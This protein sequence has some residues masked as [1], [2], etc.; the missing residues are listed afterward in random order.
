MKTLT[1]IL[2]VWILTQ[3]VYSQLYQ[4]PDTGSVPS[5]ASVT[6]NSFLAKDDFYNPFPTK[7]LRNKISVMPLSDETNI[8]PATGAAGSNI[9][10]DVSLSSSETVMDTYEPLYFRSFKGITMGNSIPP[11]P[12][13]AAGPDHFIAT[14]NTSFRISD[15]KGNTL[16]TIEA[17][18]WFNNVFTNAGAFDPKV[19][20]D[21]FAKRWIMVWLQQNDA[22]QTGTFLVSVSDDSNPIGTWYNW[23][24]PSSKNGSTPVSQ[25]GDYQGVGFD[26]NA[27]YLTTNQFSFAGSYQG[28]KI[29][30]IPKA[31]LYANTGGRCQWTDLWNVKD[32]VNNTQCFGIRPVIVYDQ[33]NYVYFL[34]QS[35]YTTGTYV[36]LFRLSNPLGT[37]SMTAVNIPVTE[38]YAPPNSSQLGTTTTIDAGSTSAFRFEPIV[39][40]RYMWAVHPVYNFGWSGVGYI[41]LDLNLNIPSEDYVYGENEYYFSYPGIAVDKDSN[42][43]IT[44]SRS[45]N[46]EYIGAYFTGKN[47]DASEFIG[48]KT[49]QAGKG[50]YVVTFGGSRNRWGD[51]MGVWLD[52][53]DESSF[54]LSTEY[55]ES[56]SNTWGVWNVHV[57]LNPYPG[58]RYYS[59]TDT[60][61]FSPT[62]KDFISDTM[63]FYFTNI[64][65]NPL[66]IDSLSLNSTEFSILPDHTFPINLNYLDSVMIRVLF[67][68]V[69]EGVL[70]SSLSVFSNDTYQNPHHVILTGKSYII[71]PA[72]SNTMYA[73]TGGYSSGAVL[74]LNHLN[75]SGSSIGLSGV[76]EIKSVSIQPITNELWGTVF[77]SPS[78]TDLYRINAATGEAFLAT[79]VSIGNLRGIA[80]ETADSAYVATQAGMLYKVNVYTGAFRQIG[81]A[82]I[83]NLYGIALNPIDGQLWGMALLNKIYKINKLIGGST[84]VGV[85][86][87]SSTIGIAFD[88]SGNLFG[89]YGLNSQTGNLIKIDTVTGIGTLIGSTGFASVNGLA[90][91]GS[92]IGT[93]E[94]NISQ[95]PDDFNLNPAYPNPFN[96]TTTIG[97][98]VAKSMKVKLTVY[99]TLGQEIKTLVNTKKM[100]GKYQTIWDGKDNAG[101][102]VAS[103]IYFYRL[104]AGSFVKTRKMM[105]IK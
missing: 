28:S 31:Q 68:P 11:D 69:T 33:Q 81:S 60:I 19:S 36:T 98:D 37:P 27:I 61:K 104:E 99:N 92:L 50:S 57:R 86:G 34:S 58:S 20:Y 87:F 71:Q 29:R 63:S 97:F 49:M 12:Y 16:K 103:G 3:S 41:R 73:V 66:I 43:V 76:T 53:S 23:A 44:Y 15:K 38:Y 6:T 8:I 102:A 42:I 70:T 55:S 64:G 13:C 32:P 40:G 4:G 47:H 91:Y 85:P 75:G 67:N 30:I 51:Y 84:Q 74:N 83:S 24:L 18:S 65:Q 17:D 105:L 26:Q 80:F 77:S 7:P 46:S 48:S 2:A 93:D 10:K 88:N 35:R 22:N 95:Y 89:T 101:H 39:R 56:P 21:H 59:A 78:I 9:K 14:V 100:P 94:S 82:S 52:P 96:P 62:E 90:V 45:S 79:S 5:G 25:W 72:L 54:W 1:G